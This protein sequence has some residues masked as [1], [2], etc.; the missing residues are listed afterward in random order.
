MLACG[1][2]NGGCEF[3]NCFGYPFFSRSQTPPKSS[4]T[5]GQNQQLAFALKG[6]TCKFLLHQK[7]WAT[8]HAGVLTCGTWIRLLLFF[9]GSGLL[10]IFLL[11]LS[12]GRFRKAWDAPTFSIQTLTSIFSRPVN[13]HAVSAEFACA[14]PFAP[15]TVGALRSSPS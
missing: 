14:C 8:T 13:L 4:P 3:C 6:L 1:V 15:C 7:A 12:E 2:A 11:P 5:K 9:A 10:K